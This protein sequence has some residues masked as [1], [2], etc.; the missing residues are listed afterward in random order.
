MFFFFKQKTA[1]E[2]RIRDWSSDVCSSDLALPPRSSIAM[3]AAEASQCVEETTPKVPRISGRV[4]NMPCRPVC[5]MDDCTNFN[6]SPTG[7]QS[8]TF[9]CHPGAAER[10][11]P[12]SIRDRDRKS[13]R[14][15]S[16]H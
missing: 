13:K 6:G 3:P 9:P 11:N 12:G 10:P 2:M 7:A 8:H 14:L 1:Y 16:S 5:F 15:N 4:V